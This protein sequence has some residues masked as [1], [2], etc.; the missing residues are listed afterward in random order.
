MW[1]HPDEVVLL[2]LSLLPS[3]TVLVLR[4]SCY[5]LM[6]PPSFS[7]TRFPPRFRPIH[8][9]SSK[10][11]LMHIKLQLPSLLLCPGTPSWSAM[12]VSAEGMFYVLA[13]SP[14]CSAIG[15]RVT[16]LC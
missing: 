7:H 2:S 15:A 1:S 10:T 13:L 5:V 14:W 9:T 4:G 3:I 12:I 8:P 16:Q 6:F 11:V